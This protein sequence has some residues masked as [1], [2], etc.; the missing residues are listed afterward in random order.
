[1]TGLIHVLLRLLETSP[2]KPL[3]KTH[4]SSPAPDPECS[5]SK[6]NEDAELRTLSNKNSIRYPI[7]LENESWQSTLRVTQRPV[8][9]EMD[10]ID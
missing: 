7:M 8:G 5:M 3:G 4:S 1:M 2:R 6:A 10:W 9:I